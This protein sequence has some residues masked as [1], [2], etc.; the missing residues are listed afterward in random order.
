M[1]LLFAG[2]AALYNFSLALSL[3][4]V[5]GSYSSIVIVVGVLLKLNLTKKDM[6]KPKNEP[7][8]SYS[9]DWNPALTHL[10][11]SLKHFGVEIIMWSDE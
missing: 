10:D 8:E 7:E 6:E 2:G 3:G 11:K 9:L 1:A 5:I 4:V